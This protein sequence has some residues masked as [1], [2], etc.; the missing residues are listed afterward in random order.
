MR[1]TFPKTWTRLAIGT[2]LCLGRGVSA[3]PEA[4]D[5]VHFGINP[6][7]RLLA[8]T[9]V[10]TAKTLWRLWPED[11]KSEHTKGEPE[12]VL[13]YSTT[14]S[15]SRLIASATSNRTLTPACREEARR[16]NQGPEVPVA[17]DKITTTVYVVL[18]AD[19]PARVSVRAAE[20]LKIVNVRPLETSTQSNGDKDLELENWTRAAYVKVSYQGSQERPIGPS[21][22]VVTGDPSKG[23]YKISTQKAGKT[24]LDQ[25]TADGLLSSA[26]SDALLNGKISSPPMGIAGGARSLFGLGGLSSFLNF[27]RLLPSAQTSLVLISIP[28]SAPRTLRVKT[29]PG[30][31]L[32][33]MGTLD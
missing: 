28:E 23:E 12:Y 11:V 21:D 13:S 33:E 31:T 32:M 5:E 9:V 6:G 17:D 7:A 2:T 20:G 24:A 1:A 16:L 3:S 26:C 30:I 22:V 18:A 14:H 29:S 4:F 19:S 10:G 25:L 8:V 27:K 15:P